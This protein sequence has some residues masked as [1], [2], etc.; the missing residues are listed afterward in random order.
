MVLPE[1]AGNRRHV[2]AGSFDERKEF[3]ALGV[4]LWHVLIVPIPI[5]IAQ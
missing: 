1:R 4:K 5:G 2:R 3:G